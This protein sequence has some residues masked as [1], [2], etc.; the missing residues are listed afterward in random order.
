MSWL[1][2]PLCAH[3]KTLLRM[4]KCNACVHALCVCVCVCV[5]FSIVGVMTE[6]PR[7]TLC[8]YRSHGQQNNLEPPWEHSRRA[9]HTLWLYKSTHTVHTH[10]HIS[11]HNN[12]NT[13]H[14]HI[15]TCIH[16][17]AQQS[18]HNTFT[19]KQLYTQCVG[20]VPRMKGSPRSHPPGLNA[21]AS[22][23]I[24]HRSSPCKRRYTSKQL[25]ATAH[26]MCMYD[27]HTMYVVCHTSHTASIYVFIMCM[28]NDVH[29]KEQTCM[30]VNTHSQWSR[31]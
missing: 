18:Q 28:L 30:Q 27:T 22:E 20:F 16:K 23:H 12:H 31:T 17:W 24:S 25:S 21:D 19:C 3:C 4:Y 6:A 10:V 13:L 14:L 1:L 15:N 7:A 11:E 2:P 5:K 8:A 9:S 29:N 26:T